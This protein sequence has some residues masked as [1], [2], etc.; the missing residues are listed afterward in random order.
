M[1]YT[2]IVSR[3]NTIIN[4]GQGIR[5]AVVSIL[6]PAD[7]KSPDRLLGSYARAVASENHVRK[8]T[9]KGSVHTFPG[10]TLGT[11]WHEARYRLG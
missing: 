2:P 9:R 10:V 4:E 6:V 1:P 3:R 11:V 7:C 5:T 8:I